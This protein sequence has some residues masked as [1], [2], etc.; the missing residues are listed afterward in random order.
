VQLL[1]TTSASGQPALLGNVAGTF[2]FSGG[3][4]RGCRKLSASFSP[5]GRTVGDKASRVA[6]ATAWL[7]PRGCTNLGQRQSGVSV[8]FEYTS[9]SRRVQHKP[10]PDGTGR[11]TVHHPDSCTASFA[12]ADLFLF[13]RK[14][15]SGVPSWGVGWVGKVGGCRLATAPSQIRVGFR[16]RSPGPQARGVRLRKMWVVFFCISLKPPSLPR[17]HRMDNRIVHAWPPQYRLP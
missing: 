5:P 14:A 11:T 7:H 8:A 13:Y 9:A 12:F 10:S 6:V 15:S 3:S 4:R 1:C 2:P 17:S 16:A